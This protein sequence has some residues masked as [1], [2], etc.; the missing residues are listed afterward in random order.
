MPED[1][2]AVLDALDFATRVWIAAAARGEV[3]VTH[4]AEKTTF[5]QL[6]DDVK[7][8]ADLTLSVA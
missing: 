3:G 1:F 6:I 2:A 8:Q 5:T 4:R 7:S